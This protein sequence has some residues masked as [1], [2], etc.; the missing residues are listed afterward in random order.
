MDALKAEGAAA[1]VQRR[2]VSFGEIPVRSGVREYECRERRHRVQSQFRGAQTL[3]FYDGKTPRENAI[4]LRPEWEKGYFRLAEVLF[5]EKFFVE[6]KVQYEIARTKTNEKTTLTRLLERIH[7]VDEALSDNGFYFRQLMP[8]KDICIKS[9]G[10]V[11][12]M[13]EMQVFQAAKQMQ[14]FIYLVGDAKIEECGYRFACW[15]VE[16]IIEFVKDEK[17]KLIGAVAT[18]YHFDHVGERRRVLGM[19]L[20]LK[21]PG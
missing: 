17:M 9:S 6:A 12:K 4:H 7:L 2:S 5:E 8:G 10:K 3:E 16:G 14:N 21:F 20:E 18:H 15:D 13:V 19:H 1:R 11:S